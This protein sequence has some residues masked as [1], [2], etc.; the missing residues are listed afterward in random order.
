MATW[1]RKRKAQK[2]GSF[3][4]YSWATYEENEDMAVAGSVTA[5]YRCQVSEYRLTATPT[6]VMR[7]EC[8]PVADAV[9]QL[10]RGETCVV[11]GFDMAQLRQRLAGLGIG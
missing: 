11:A 9:P 7:S 4:E 8:A 10:E 5:A 6:T 2:W 1:R 3:M